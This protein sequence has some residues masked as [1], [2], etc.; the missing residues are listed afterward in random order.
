MTA[1][2]YRVVQ[3]ARRAAPWVVLGESLTDPAGWVDVSRHR[4]ETAAVEYVAEVTARQRDLAG[5]P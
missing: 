3:E 1:R 4:T 2:L 5:T